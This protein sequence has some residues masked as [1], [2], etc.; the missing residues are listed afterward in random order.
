[1]IGVT[2]SER[3]V[4]IAIDRSYA[5]TSDAA[6]D[7]HRHLIHPTSKRQYGSNVA[8]TVHADPDLWVDFAAWCELRSTVRHGDS[9]DR[10]KEASI[11]GRAAEKI[12]QEI[13]RLA[14]HPAYRG[15]GV[16]G[17]DRRAL[18]ARRCGAGRWWP[19]STQARANS[20]G[21]TF[22]VEVATLYPQ[23][24]LQGGAVFTVWSP[25]RD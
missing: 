8:V 19:T 1:M 11:L 6:M 5:G 2:V 22:T 7:M 23:S 20:D 18:P 16:R 13:D 24:V 9:A 4:H 14:K 15:I 25:D 12:T 17:R 3:A 21:T 10:Q